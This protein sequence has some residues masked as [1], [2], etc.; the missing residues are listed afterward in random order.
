MKMSC[1]FYADHTLPAGVTL[2]HARYD[3][4]P[5]AVIGPSP[6]AP[7]LA[8]CGPGRLLGRVAS[9]GRPGR[10]RPLRGALGPRWVPPRVSRPSSAHKFRMHTTQI[11]AI[12]EAL[13]GMDGIYR[14]VH[15]LVEAIVG[16]PAR[17]GSPTASAEYFFDRTVELCDRFQLQEMLSHVDAVEA[18]DE[19]KRGE[20]DRSR[21]VPSD[22]AFW[23][24]EPRLILMQHRREGKFV[25]VL[26]NV[27]TV[28]T[29]HGPVK[30]LQGLREIGALSWVVLPD[31]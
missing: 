2:R 25:R 23:R 22:R 17:Y 19:A 14:S 13:D 26:G 1:R 29:H 9:P 31:R 16:S 6:L 18:L 15:E 8:F 24:E 11:A 20:L 27:V 3:A 10:V 30:W 12:G 5:I 28:R 4:H 7:E 21:A